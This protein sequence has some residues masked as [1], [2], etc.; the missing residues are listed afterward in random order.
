MKE[1]NLGELKQVVITSLEN[2]E[3]HPNFKKIREASDGITVP[4]L[5]NLTSIITEIEVMRI[6]IKELWEKDNEISL[7]GVNFKNPK[8]SK[9]VITELYR[10]LDSNN[11]DFLDLTVRRIRK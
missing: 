5:M 4:L 2:F 6:V 9:E 8:N 3:S 7:E 10:R 11:R 1:L